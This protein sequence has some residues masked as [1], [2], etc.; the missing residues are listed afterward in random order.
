MAISTQIINGGGNRN[1]LKVNPDGSINT[2]QTPNPP[3]PSTGTV[4]TFRFLS[5]VMGSTGMDSGTINLNVDGSATAQ[6]FTVDSDEDFDI[7][8][9]QV[10]FIVADSA[11][12]HS[13]FGNINA[14]TNGFDLEIV[15]EGVTTKLINAVKTGGQL[16]AQTGFTHPFGDGT[17]SFELSNWTGTE[18]A[19]VAVM[20][21]HDF[22]PGGIR[23]GRGSQ[24][25]LIARV[26]DDLTGLTEFTV[27]VL[28]YKHYP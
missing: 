10:V 20:S 11:V 24:N 26:N 8:V 16:I 5:G 3:V 23:I 27:R 12:V 7:H 19:Q 18:D 22:V 14:L 6:E 28:G 4:N 15:E 2:T 17:L 1:K 9:M 25:K 21:L 13:K